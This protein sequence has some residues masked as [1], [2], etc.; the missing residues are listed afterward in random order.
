MIKKKKDEKVLTRMTGYQLVATIEALE[1]EGRVDERGFNLIRSDKKVAN[2]V[3]KLINLRLCLPTEVDKALLSI[4]DDSKFFGP[5]DWQRYYNLDIGNCELPISIRE[6]EKILYQSCPFE[7]GK[8]IRD[9]HYLFC[10]PDNWNGVPLTVLQWQKIVPV[11]DP[12]NYSTSISNFSTH[13]DVD[14]P[15]H[16]HNLRGDC[17]QKDVAKNK[18]YLMPKLLPGRPFTNYTYRN[19][20]DLRPSDYEPA[21][22]IECIPLHFL[23]FEKNNERINVFDK[24]LS[25][26]HGNTAD[27]DTNHETIRV[28]N[29][30][31]FGLNIIDGYSVRCMPMGYGSIFLYHKLKP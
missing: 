21:K 1:R 17:I 22:L 9:T 8:K 28:G 18:W 30:D 6:L 2:E 5:A 19:Q 23:I 15:G 4:M 24:T 14:E 7:K 10:L 12:D 31:G 13:I 16:G 11:G 20:L 25:C 26:A 27:C 29:F 3:G